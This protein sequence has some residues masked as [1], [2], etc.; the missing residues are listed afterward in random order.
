MKIIF[1]LLLTWAFCFFTKWDRK[2]EKRNTVVNWEQ[3]FC[4]NSCIKDQR[5]NIYQIFAFDQKSIVDFRSFVCFK[6][7]KKFQMIIIDYSLLQQPLALL[8]HEKN[9]LD[10]S[11]FYFMSGNF[12][13]L[14]NSLN[15]STKNIAQRCI[16]F[17][18]R[19]KTILRPKQQWIQWLDIAESEPSLYTSSTLYFIFLDRL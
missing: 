4:K 2:E 18:L 10:H 11:F 1:D 12:E 9:I 15:S 8:L 5:M 6:S 3:R 14:L 13:Y 19:Q 7:I 17:R 16:F